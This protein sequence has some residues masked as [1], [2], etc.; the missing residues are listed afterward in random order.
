ME[1]LDKMQ[2][3]LNSLDQ[4]RFYQYLIGFLSVVFVLILLLLFQYYRSISSLQDEA[5]EVNRLRKKAQKILTEVQKIQRDKKEIDAI[6][7]KDKGFKIAGY[8]EDLISRLGLAQKKSSALEVSSATSEGKYEEII[9][10]A[11]FSGLS[12]KELTEILQEIESKKRVFIKELDI[13]ASEKPA[14][15]INVTLIIAT[16]QPKPQETGGTE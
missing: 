1:F 13:V 10:D 15:S 2:A 6:I 5:L 11:K 16:L 9:L 7:A 12:M 3:Y 4:R 8:F 14:N